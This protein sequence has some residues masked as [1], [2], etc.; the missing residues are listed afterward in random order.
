MPLTAAAFTIGAL[1]LAGIPPLSA[2]WSKDEIVLAVADGL[3][4]IFLV[5]LLIAVV[6]SAVYMARAI[7]TVFFGP[8]S[9][10]AHDAADPPPTMSAPLAVLGVLTLI[11]GFIALPFDR[12][13]LGPYQG[14]GHFLFDAEHGPHDFAFGPMSVVA[15]VLAI[16]GIALGWWLYAQRRDIVDRLRT[17]FSGV[18]RLVVERYYMD[19]MYQWLVDQVVMRT[20]KFVA[21]FDR[22][23]VNDGGVNG[24]GWIVYQ[25]G[26]RLR[27][28]VTGFIADYGIWMLFGAVA[29]A[30]FIWLRTQ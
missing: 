26:A 17:Q 27:Y 20:G 8:L 7:R 25:A 22:K 14:I 16:G 12:L 5:L 11:V 29:L 28:H 23:V 15:T 2:F 10:E 13:G 30:L 19:S 1:A 18:H 21:V 3:N 9:P 6:L 4:P 24:S